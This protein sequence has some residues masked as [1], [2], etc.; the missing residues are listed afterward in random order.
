MPMLRGARR[1]AGEDKE[2]EMTPLSS[3][4]DELS[5]Q[6]KMRK[7]PSKGSRRSSAG[8][9]GKPRLKRDA[10]ILFEDDLAAKEAEKVDETFKVAWQLWIPENQEIEDSDDEDEDLGGSAKPIAI[11]PVQEMLQKIKV[12]SVRIQA[13]QGFILYMIFM[14][15]LCTSISLELQMEEASEIETSVKRYVT[16]A[17]GANVEDLTAIKNQ[18]EFWD[19]AEHGLLPSLFP[20]EQWYN[21]EAWTQDESGYIQLYTKLAMDFQMVQHRVDVEELGEGDRFFPF[22]TKSW[23]AYGTATRSVKPFGPSHD[24]AKY[25]YEPDNVGEFG[26]GGF[27]MRFPRDQPDLAYET[28]RELK[29]DKWTDKQTRAVFIDFPVYNKNRKFFVVVAIKVDF[30]PSGTA[31]VQF[32]TE[33][34]RVEVFTEARDYVRVVFLIATVG[35]A[36]LQLKLHYNMAQEFQDKSA[37]LKAFWNK[38]DLVRL[39]LFFVAVI[40]YVWI[41]RHPIY[42]EMTLPPTKFYNFQ[43]L[44]V[45]KKVYVTIQAVD[46]LLTI[47]CVFKYLSPFP[48]LGIFVHTFQRALADLSRFMCVVLLL[49]FGFSVMG[50]ILFGT[51]V[52]EFSTI[53]DSFFASFNMMIGENYFYELADATSLVQAALFFFPFIIMVSLVLFEMITAILLAAYD[54]LQDHFQN[55]D[56]VDVHGEV[57]KTIFLGRQPTIYE[58]TQSIKH[59]CLR[60]MRPGFCRR[61]FRAFGEHLKK[62]GKTKGMNIQRVNDFSEKH[63]MELLDPDRSFRLSGK[64]SPSVKRKIMRAQERVDYGD[65]IVQSARCLT[66]YEFCYLL[67]AFRDTDKNIRIGNSKGSQSFQVGEDTVAWG[68]SQAIFRLYSKPVPKLQ[69]ED[70]HTKFVTNSLTRLTQSVRL[71]EDKLQI[72]LSKSEI[73]DNKKSGA[74]NFASKKRMIRL[75]KD[76]ER[77][78]YNRLDTLEERDLKESPVERGH[79]DSGDSTEG[80]RGG[81]M[82][83]YPKRRPRDKLTEKSASVGERELKG[84]SRTS[85]PV[86]SRG[87]DAALHQLAEDGG[88]EPKSPTRNSL[89]HLSE[90]LQNVIRSARTSDVKMPTMSRSAGISDDIVPFG[91]GGEETKDFE[92]TVSQRGRR[93]RRP[94]SRETR[95]TVS[96][97]TPPRSEASPS[98]AESDSSLL[99]RPSGRAEGGGGLIRLD[100]W[101]DDEHL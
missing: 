54:Q 13:V 30:D 81:S 1:V 84:P 80:P 16:Q 94:T 71:I 55:G 8:G 96:S 44:I 17:G 56:D 49:I 39:A 65:P 27:F 19:W 97:I 78:L 60:V 43:E 46:L 69:V 89:A 40:L 33:S 85:S 93:R 28:L 9:L 29:S 18:E 82:P 23:P 7:S 62:K 66:I 77:S 64:L 50:H 70:Q 11:L 14:L 98:G 38:F 76:A 4:L 67:H 91:G 48:R 12:K 31:H 51:R 88:P 63:L 15:T 2:S 72:H 41:L 86:P 68:I 52:K 10:S 45:Y 32:D 57:W 100:S 47:I 61:F 92:A 75:Q 74:L 37:Y 53:E 6:A 42:T 5:R 24:P 22:V 26:G 59:I 25:T 79:S 3:S 21:Q 58:Q 95:T 87:V 34:F 35:M 73:L 99:R 20:D 36:L 83:E 101:Q 90:D